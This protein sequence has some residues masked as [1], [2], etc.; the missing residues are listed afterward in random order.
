MDAIKFFQGKVGKVFF[1]APGGLKLGF[2][3]EPAAEI[4]IQDSRRWSANFSMPI[5]V[6]PDTSAKDGKT[7]LTIR[8]SLD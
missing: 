5:V 2:E 3:M 1:T 6:R 4:Y 7:K 8:L